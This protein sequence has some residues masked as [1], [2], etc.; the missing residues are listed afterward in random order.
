MLD[1]AN[2]TSRIP[3]ERQ[4]TK[5]IWRKR[6][7]GERQIAQ[8][9]RRKSKKKVTANKPACRPRAKLHHRGVARSFRLSVRRLR[10]AYVPNK[11]RKHTT[12]SFW[13]AAQKFQVRSSCSL[14]R[15]SSIFT[16]DL[17]VRMSAS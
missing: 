16:R 13:K 10:A 1:P 12:S 14:S 9:L 17:Y 15:L 7:E 3:N 4:N 5:R 8:R 6:N 11:L 2:A